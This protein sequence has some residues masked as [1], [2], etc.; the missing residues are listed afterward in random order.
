M[1]LLNLSELHRCIFKKAYNLHHIFSYS[2]S[3]PVE[4][5]RGQWLF[6][7]MFCTLLLHRSSLK[8]F[9]SLYQFQRAVLIISKKRNRFNVNEECKVRHCKIFLGN[10][11]FHLLL[12]FW[13]LKL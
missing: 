6:L 12:L 3:N 7:L 5:K 10:G 8:L 2:I 1:L 4:I 13:K 9:K 11:K